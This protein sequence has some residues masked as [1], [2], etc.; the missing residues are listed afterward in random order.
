[1]SDTTPGPVA[2]TCQDCGV[3]PGKPHEDGC[4]VA[5]CLR[6]GYQRLS[7]SEPHD[8]GQDIWTGQWPGEADAI[9][10]GWYAKL[11]GHGW[12]RCGAGDPDGR[13]DLNRLSAMTARWDRKTLRWEEL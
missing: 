11:T 9:R 7:C 1:M 10:L 13:P 8:C 6:T 4:D 3:R 5:R 12:V 2:A